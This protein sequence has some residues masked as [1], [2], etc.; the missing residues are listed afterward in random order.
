MHDLKELRSRPDRAAEI[1]DPLDRRLWVL[2][3]ISE[4]TAR[5]SQRPIRIG[6]CAEES[7]TGLPRCR[8]EWRVDFIE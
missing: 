6:S 5:A 1:A 7:H 3:V 8:W 2:E 4:L